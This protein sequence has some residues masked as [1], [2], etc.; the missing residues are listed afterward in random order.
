M[1][2]AVIE[3]SNW[4]LVE[5][6]R[7][8]LINGDHPFAGGLATIVEII[9]HKRVLIDGPSS[10]PALAVP[11]QAIALSKC[12][13]SQFVIEGLL[14]GSRHGTVKKQWEK[15]QIDAKWK[16]SNWAKKREQAQRRKA[17]TDFERFQV[18]RL[19]KQ[20]RFEERKA[21]AKI[22]ASA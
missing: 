4:R 15:A 13:L 6:G 10:V 3:G 7:V 20:A 1:G 16:E 9:D 2:E 5:V 11:R 21:L 22:K 14:R 17:L 12:L 8:V 18:M 19:K